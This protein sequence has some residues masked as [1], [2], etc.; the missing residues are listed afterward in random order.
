MSM[1]P[2]TPTSAAT[3]APERTA[4]LAAASLGDA[5]LLVLELGSV[6]A[7]LVADVAAEL[8]VV[9]ALG[10]PVLRF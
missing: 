5:E 10:L 4:G 7:L 6:V 8:L 1:P 3:S 9:E 2:K